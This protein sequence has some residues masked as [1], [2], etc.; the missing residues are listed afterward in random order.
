MIQ[1]LAFV[2]LLLTASLLVGC[3]SGSENTGIV[4]GTVTVDGQPVESGS[5]AFWPLDGTSRTD[6]G[7]I[8]QGRYQVAASIGTSKVEI[9]VPKRVG[10]RKTRNTPDSPVRPVFKQILPPK[11]N[12]QTELQVDVVAGETECNFDLSSK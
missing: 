6:G 10:E 7:E 9:R 3:G 1:R 5:I 12:E 8:V 11:Y 2:T 4:R